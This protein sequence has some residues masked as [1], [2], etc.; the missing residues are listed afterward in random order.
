MTALADALTAAQTRAVAALGKQYVGGT[1]NDVTVRE[2]LHSIG[3]TDEVDTD[4]L[5]AAWDILKAAGAQPPGE[6]KA[7]TNGTDD[8]P[9]KATPNQR[10]YI[11]DLLRK[12]DFPPFAEQDLANLTHDA[13]SEIITAL[14]N[15]TYDPTKY[16]VPV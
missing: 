16:D 9:R 14:R 3:L 5:L 10:S 8:A 7:A 15:G 4:R 11:V 6:Q 2:D 13:A 1:I 12:G